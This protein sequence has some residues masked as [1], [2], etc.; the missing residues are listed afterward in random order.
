MG[1][2]VQYL[3]VTY[4]FVS[5]WTS[6][7][8]HAHAQLRGECLWDTPH[9]HRPRPTLDPRAIFERVNPYAYVT[10]ATLIGAV[11]ASAVAVCRSALTLHHQDNRRPEQS[12]THLR[13]T[14]GPCHIHG[15]GV[16]ILK[17][18][19]RPRRV[20]LPIII[21]A[22]ESQRHRM[23][24][25]SAMDKVCRESRCIMCVLCAIWFICRIPRQQA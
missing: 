13:S 10:Q 4:S 18:D 23:V 21:E 14:E 19:I 9:A 12:Q 2:A 25:D 24:R 17:D 16:D 15:Y 1:I 22:I 11:V 5:L 20:R 8:V 7:R 6:Q 3:P